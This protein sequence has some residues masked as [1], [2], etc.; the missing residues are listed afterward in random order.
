M[1][2]LVTFGWQVPGL[3]IFNAAVFL[4]DKSEAINVSHDTVVLPYFVPS[5]VGSQLRCWNCTDYGAEEDT[6]FSWSFWVSSLSYRTVWLHLQEQWEKPHHTG[7]IVDAIQILFS[8]WQLHTIDKMK[9][10]ELTWGCNKVILNKCKLYWNKNIIGIWRLLLEMSP[11]SAYKVSYEQC[12][13]WAVLHIPQQSQACW[14]AL[15][16]YN[17]WRRKAFW[18]PLTI[19]WE[20][21]VLPPS[22]LFS[23]RSFQT[24]FPTET[25]D[26]TC[27]DAGGSQPPSWARYFH[28]GGRLLGGSRVPQ[29]QV[30]EG[31]GE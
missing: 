11:V 4:E 21:E 8:S 24:L 29:V 26:G 23:Y 18:K 2:F 30:A 7:V 31:H 25:L 27:S 15:A 5:T 10:K 16:G 22:C 17:K 28:A 6:A 3:P 12:S 20:E 1:L 19:L 14:F 9:A 13:L